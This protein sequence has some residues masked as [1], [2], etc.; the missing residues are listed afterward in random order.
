MLV[1]YFVVQ[2][3]MNEHKSIRRNQFENNYIPRAIVLSASGLLITRENEESEVS[4][5]FED[6][7]TILC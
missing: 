2:S 5:L 3:R 4:E 7:V 1:T 6:H